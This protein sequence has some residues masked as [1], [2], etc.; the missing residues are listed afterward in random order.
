MEGV[1]LKEVNGLNYGHLSISDV[2]LNLTYEVLEASDEATLID[3]T[4]CLADTF[5]G[6]GI[7]GVRVSEPMVNA[8]GLSRNDMFDFTYGYLKNVVHQGYC[9]VAK[10]MTTDNVIG[11]VACEI[12][13]PDEEIP[14]FED[15]LEPMN[16]IISL[17]VE[18]DERFLRTVQHKTGK[19]VESGEYIHAFMCGAKLAKYKRLAIASL[20]ELMEK[21]AL[22]EG[23]K[24]IFLEAT[25]PRS[26]NMVVNYFDF[27][28]VYDPDGKPILTEYCTVDA[29]KSVPR[30][31]SP[32][33]RILYKALNPEDEL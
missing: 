11:M 27:H 7:D 32:D 20:L 29:F 3:A 31:I 2:D 1:V 19:K 5:A 30:E 6:I 26:A 21:K 4:N 8:C 12:F 15:N 18:L 24:G 28:L 9:F 14:V 10:D 25:N 22:E 17:L 13:N 33:C 23:Y 16:K